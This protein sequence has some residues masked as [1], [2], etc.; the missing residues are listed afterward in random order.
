MPVASFEIGR[1]LPVALLRACHWRSGVL[2]ALGVTLASALAGRSTREVGLVLVTVLVG[3]FALGVQNDLVDRDRDRENDRVAKPIADGYLD[4]STAMFTITVSM[5]LV[6]PL[7]IAN[8]QVAGLCHLAFLVVAML[9]NA[10][11]LRRSRLSFLPW[12]LS[13]ALLPA[14]LAYGGWGGD[15]SDTAPTVTITICAAL[16]GIGVHLL[17]ALPGLVDE[18]R[19]G[20]KT[21]PLTI[22]L[23][24]GA[25]KTLL[26]TLG[27]LAVVTVAI[28]AVGATT[29]LTQ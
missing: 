5:L 2:I 23:K 20:W 1:S 13:F 22:A 6:V 27:W 28:A 11:L 8:G 15:G 9:G 10:G 29:G 25:P 21:L 18:N 17:L 24:I 26:V 4:P 12:A 7:S 3:Q 14:F 19:A 16:L